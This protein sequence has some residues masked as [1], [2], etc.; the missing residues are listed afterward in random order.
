MDIYNS[1]IE[2]LGA[3][4]EAESPLPYFRERNHK[5]PLVD[6]GLLEEEKTGFGDQTAFRILPYTMQHGY[7]RAEEKITLQTVV[8]ENECMKATFLP[9]Y[10][11]RLYSLFDK[12]RGREL[13]YVNPVFQPAN[14][15]IRNAWFSGGIEWNLGYFGHSCLT[16]APVYFAT[17][18]DENGEKFLRMYEYERMQGFFYQIDFYLPSKQNQL[19]AHVTIIN[20]HDKEMPLYWWTNIAVRQDRDVRVFSGSES[21]ICIKP[22]SMTGEQSVHGFGHDTM[23]YLEATQGADASYPDKF[24][25]SN[26]YFFQ[27]EEESRHTWEACTYN[28]GTAF[29]ERSTP[30]LRYRKMFCWGIHPGGHRWQ[31]HLT[32]KGSGEYLEIQAGLAKTQVHVSSI[33]AEQTVS[34]TQIFGGSDIDTSLTTGEWN[35]SAVNVYSQIEKLCSSNLLEQADVKYQANALHKP[36]KVIAYGS[37]WGALESMRDSRAVP[38]SMLF[39]WQ[40]SNETAVWACLAEQGCIPDST[41]NKIPESW[42]TDGRWLVLLE[43]SLNNPQNINTTSLLHYGVMLYENGRWQEGID[44][45]CKSMQLKPNPAA[46]FC[47]AQA[48]YQSGIP[49]MALENLLLALNICDEQDFKYLAEELISL[50]CKIGSPSQA[51]ELYDSLPN[52]CKQD[53]RVMLQAAKAALALGQTDFLEKLLEKDLAQIREGENSVSDMWFVVEAKKQGKTMQEIAE[54]CELPYKFDY[55]MSV[56]H[57]KIKN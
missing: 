41:D 4:V 32:E 18:T 57:R 28:D 25:Y 51:W 46:A 16:C 27:N 1:T 12:T 54:K 45:L 24:G 43:A 26:E 44:A 9:G 13:L 2:L 30:K 3:Q 53:E 11:G 40:N 38:K 31:E 6:A 22:E 35:T 56:P 19:H 20:S 14:L 37:E 49:Q 42:M 39:R 29:W 17:C 5:K 55:R 33:G 48:Y 8:L 50:Y 36:D 52:S 15:A 23:P 10:G 21:V 47:L 7:K 34:F